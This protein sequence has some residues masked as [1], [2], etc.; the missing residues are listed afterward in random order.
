[1]RL[2]ALI[3]FTGLT[4]SFCGGATSWDDLRQS[5]DL[6]TAKKQI[7]DFLPD[8]AISRIEKLLA[9]PD[10]EPGARA[11]LLTLLG[12]ARVRANQPGEA[13]KTLDD[14]V[15]R[16]FSPAHLWR[17]YA[18]A[19]L[20]RYR[21]AI[22]ELA[23]ID[24]QSMKAN[25]NLQ[26]GKLHLALGNP[27]KA[28]ES[29]EPLLA[30]SDP[31][32]AREALLQLI[33]LSLSQ[34]LPNEAEK[35]LKSF[36]PSGPVEENLVLFL[37]G[38]LQFLRGERLAA[39]GTFQTLLKESAIRQSLPA[40]LFHETTLALADSLALDGNENAAVT[41]ILETLEKFPES[42]LIETFFS[43][44]RTWTPKAET[45]PVI[46]TL[47]SWLPTL[48]PVSPFPVINRGRS[49]SQ[50]SSSLPTPV[51]SARGLLAL[52]FLATLNLRSTT[53]GQ[54]SEGQLQFTLLQLL[55]PPGSLPIGRC[56]LELGLLQLKDGEYRHALALFSMLEENRASPLTRA[57]A[58]SL[59]GKAAFALAE[60]TKAS[61]LYLE[62]E[63]IA[64]KIRESN[65]AS[66]AALNSGITLLAT[67][68]SKELDEIT[69]NLASPEAKS[70]LILE[71][72]LFLS[73]QRDP[74]AR[75]FLV[76]FLTN[77][78]ND[79]RTPE[80]TLALA[81]SAIF[82]PPFD[83]GLARTHITTLRF[84]LNDQPLLAARRILVLLALK[85]NLRLAEDFLKL[86]PQN[87]LA[88]RVLFQLGQAY[89]SPANPDDREIGKANLQFELLID[90]YPESRFAD[91]ARYYSA[92]TSVTLKTKSADQKAIARFRELIEAG[93][94]LANE[95][96]INL[97]SFYIDRDQQQSALKE[98]ETFL[99]TLTL[100]P[101]D[102]RRLLILGADAANQIG[103][104]E[105]ALDYYEAMLQLK[106][107]PVADRHRANYIR[108]QALEK[109]GRTAEALEAYYAVINRN[110]DPDATTILEW[111]WFD[112]CG[113]EGA[114]ALLEK[115][116]RWQAAITLAEK[117]GASGSPRSEDAREIA[118]R[119]A[120]EH[121]I[122]RESPVPGKEK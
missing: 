34:N 83:P 16:E 68:R 114:L 6:I 79:P 33:S 47:T 22:N 37:N 63:E 23:K 61:Q 108:G 110:F 71:R 75:D 106:D 121:F 101:S 118:D 3:L 40:P 14:P 100:A 38:R 67:S 24:R 76:T 1:M 122:Y 96:A 48:T 43:R 72:G 11:E 98:I 39:V 116:E 88:D 41:S 102:R 9:L 20:G 8:L 105:S 60:P 35:L 87:P 51:P 107:L 31:N 10:L 44:L 12:E 93:G 49:A 73:S 104:H 111:K 119:L 54:R 77:F 103:K 29:L 36:K 57:Y 7:A 117:I 19:R 94:V 80:A 65:F 45:A 115:E 4:T 18:L 27:E 99:S 120:L 21:D 42:P 95:A 70:F 89:R 78:P 113:I 56:L 30:F 50:L 85:T 53:P 82:S 55:A 92:L 91:A 25:A 32:L 86:A 28:R 59:A 84:D 62:A 15:L 46:E 26:T 97:C 109:L 66:A 81:E 74:A 13:L 2:F 17:S 52:E 5:P 58:K 69:R 90:Q 64:R 112:K